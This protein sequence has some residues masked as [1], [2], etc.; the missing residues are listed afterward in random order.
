MNKQYATLDDKI[1][2]EGEGNVFASK[3]GKIDP[4]QVWSKG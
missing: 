1:P 3:K 2:Y 4:K